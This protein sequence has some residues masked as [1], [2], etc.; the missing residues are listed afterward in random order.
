M[1]I[2]D[3]AKKIHAKTPSIEAEQLAVDLNARI[4]RI[5]GLP[6]EEVLR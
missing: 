3:L 1:V 2:I 5:F 4:W 6:A